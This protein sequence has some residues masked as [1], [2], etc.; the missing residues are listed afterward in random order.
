VNNEIIFAGFGGQ[1]ILFAGKLLSYAV[2]LSGYEVSWMPSYGPEMRGGTA[3]CHVTISDE[4]ISSPMIISPGI[5]V[6]MNKPSY[7]KFAHTVS[8][9]GTIINDSTL[10]EAQTDGAK[11]VNIPASR[12]ALDC[13][14]HKLANMVMIGKIIKETGILTLD[15]IMEAL[16]KTVPSSKADLIEL[17]K[18]MIMTGYETV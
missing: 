18:R 10:F 11:C 6:S 9:G 17:N 13:N 15:S 2:M 4:Q 1:G 5:L 8:A 14:A 3:N 16:A 7:D 12:I